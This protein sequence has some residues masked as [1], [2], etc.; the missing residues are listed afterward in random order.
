[1]KPAPR[2]QPGTRD[3]RGGVTPD[4]QQRSILKVLKILVRDNHIP[5]EVCD[6]LGAAYVF[7]R[8]TEHRLQEF[9]DQQTHDL[10]IDAQGQDRLAASM[11]FTDTIEFFSQLDQHRNN[12]HRHFKFLLE[13][14]DSESKQPNLEEQLQGICV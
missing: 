4:L 10:P 8:N 5:A 3:A 9:G 2:Q 14:K 13:A 7:L 11:G 6:E 1:M 12:V